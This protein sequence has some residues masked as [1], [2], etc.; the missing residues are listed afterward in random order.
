MVAATQELLSND[1]V[2][3]VLAHPQ[4][5][6]LLGRQGHRYE[7]PVEAVAVDVHVSLLGAVL[8]SS[9]LVSYWPRVF[10]QQVEALPAEVGHLVPHGQPPGVVRQLIALFA[11]RADE[12]SEIGSL[13]GVGRPD[14]LSVLQVA[15]ESPVHEELWLVRLTV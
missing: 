6:D 5:P 12:P 14:G 4:D 1:L 2:E 10:H 13:V 8:Q 9:R 7:L 15:R 11:H 3:E